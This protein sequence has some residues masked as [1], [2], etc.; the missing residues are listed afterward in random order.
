MTEN[1]LPENTDLNQS[2]LGWLLKNK[3]KNERGDPLG[4][5][6]HYFMIEPYRDWHWK[7]CCMKSAQIGWSTLAILK[8]LYGSIHRG[9]NCI[10]TLPTFDDVKDFVPSKVNKIIED[11]PP[12]LRVVGKS[13]TLTKKAI[14]NNFI[15]YRGTHGKK[16]AIMHTS[17]LN[18]YDEVDASNLATI[19]TYS[20]R[21]QKS[22]Y[23]GEWYFS[24]PIR[25]GGIDQMYMN[26]D[27]RRWMIQ[28]SRCNHYQDLRYD[29]NVDEDQKIYICAK[30]KQ[31]LSEED[32][33][34]GEWVINQKG[35]EMHGYHIN[36]LMCPWV[37]AKEL[38]YLKETK[39]P[40]TFHTMILGL[41]YIASEDKVPPEMIINNI[42]AE[43]NPKMRN[44]MGV[45]VGY[46]H[47]HYVLGNHDGIFQ[48]GSVET[49]DEIENLMMKYKPVTVIDAMPDSYPRRNYIERNGA[50]KG[51]QV[52]CCFYKKNLMRK[53]LYQWGEKKQQGFVYMERTKAIDEAV[54]SIKGG[55]MV[56]N[57]PGRSSQS[58]AD[59]ELKE[60]IFHW[61]NIY[62]VTEEN[63]VGIPESRW[64]KQGHEHLVHSTVYF[65]AALS[66]V[67]R[68]RAGTRTVEPWVST[69]IEIIGE[70]MAALPILAKEPVREDDWIYS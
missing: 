16:A 30:C 14:G 50:P 41:P 18:V 68:L 34:D 4:F 60:F 27:M 5:D 28:C 24:N 38:V 52:Y 51:V 35:K 23:K 69:G 44:A 53:E 67:Q 40:E 2:V 13:D 11:N 15:W 12:L 29:L 25:P 62:K 43:E 17:D 32:R 70:E 49:W 20:S 9:L 6:E 54:A 47:K 36:Q 37:S 7:Q 31:P 33:H 8:T 63:Q 19:D 56:F 66:K 55:D 61:G 21:L 22:K 57:A 65:Q 39:S 10:Y 3:L 58:Y 1:N 42:V 46:H 59:S 26:S 48:T 64:E 45:D